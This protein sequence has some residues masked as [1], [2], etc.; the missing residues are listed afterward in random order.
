MLLQNTEASMTN[1]RLGVKPGMALEVHCSL[2]KLGFVDGGAETIINAI[3]QVVGNDGAIVMPSFLLSPNL[4]LNETDRKL[5]L[6]AKIRILQGDDELNAMGIVSD[7]FRRMPDVITGQGIFRVSAWGRD[8]D[9]HSLGFQHLIDTNGWALLLGVDIY[10]LS[11]MHYVEDSLPAEISNRF[12]PSK[13]ALEL[14]PAD[15]WFIEAWEPPVKP[16]YTIQDRAY[17]NGFIRDGMI[18]NGKCML[19]QVREVV[20]LYRQALQ[21]DPFGLYGLK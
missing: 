10:R 19:L 13:E 3:K 12:K 14:Y 4:P 5:G 11:S 15:Q 7:T 6:T 2:S 8:A 17:E 20:E 16:W 1:R 18:G 21:T 9:K